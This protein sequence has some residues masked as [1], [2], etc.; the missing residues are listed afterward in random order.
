MNWLQIGAFFVY[1]L[2]LLSAGIGCFQW[3]NP[4]QNCIN[5]FLYL[6]ETLL[7]GS[8]IVIGASLYGFLVVGNFAF[9]LFF[10]FI[11]FNAPGMD[12]VY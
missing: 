5:R 1:I 6:G 8:I 9:E 7:L 3:L 2:A 10:P 4:R 12:N 11:A